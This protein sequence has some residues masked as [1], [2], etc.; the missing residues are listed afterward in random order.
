MDRGVAIREA[1]YE[2][3]AA[4]VGSED[5]IGHPGAASQEDVPG[6]SRLVEDADEGDFAPAFPRGLDLAVQLPPHTIPKRQRG[7]REIEPVPSRAPAP[8]RA[9]EHRDLMPVVD[10]EV[11]LV[12][13]TGDLLRLGQVWSLPAMGGNC[14]AQVESHK[15]EERDDS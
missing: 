10:D 14:P 12:R 6:C 1:C 5:F 13:D 9:V 7:G 2:A 8:D 4:A 15:S 3:G 11:A